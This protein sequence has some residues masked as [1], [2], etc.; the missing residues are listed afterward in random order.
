MDDTEQ[1][2]G[3]GNPSHSRQKRSR[4]GCL[5]CRTRRRKCDEGK[6]K[7]SNCISKGFECRYAAAF[8]I[9]GKNN[10]TPDVSTSSKYTKVQFVSKAS[11]K[12]HNSSEEYGG[13]H[14]NN[15]SK[16]STTSPI[17]QPESADAEEITG[18]DELATTRSSS[19]ENYEF[20]LHGLLA[21]GAGNAGIINADHSVSPR[22]VLA[23]SISSS[24]LQ[25][26]INVAQAQFALDGFS[27]DQGGVENQPEQS[28]EVIGT[29][30]DVIIE[31]LSH[32]R[33]LELLKHYRYQIAPWLDICDRKHSF[34]CEVLGQSTAS[35]S[36]RC[37]LLSLAE[38]ALGREKDGRQ[39]PNPILIANDMERGDQIDN[40]Q[41][42]LL[43]V[44]PKVGHAIAD[45]SGF[46]EQ[47]VIV[48]LPSNLQD[49]TLPKNSVLHL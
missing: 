5:T 8:Q 39:P 27:S 13:I 17:Q 40:T 48:S 10:F 24:H 47:D 2:D 20:A 49:L 14:T 45:L 7:C 31:D 35:K 42:G 46:W 9:L 15:A 19:A 3:T 25:D 26:K 23:D 30:D 41:N 32:E 11:E 37:A 33:A 22:T 4:A 44:L 16:D 18:N 12:Q 1:A 34:G 28:W 38:A 21:L 29:Q 43:E 6:P 36:L